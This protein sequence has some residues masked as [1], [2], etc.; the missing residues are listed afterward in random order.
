M[1]FSVIEIIDGDTFKVFPKW[2]WNNDEGDLVRPTGYNTPELGKPGFN[3]NKERLANLL[4]G[5]TVQL[6]NPIKL[7]FGRLLCDVALSNRN[8]ASY[9]PKCS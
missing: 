5:K 9:F 3:Q 7:T 8:L 2:K 1:N 6:S 4:L